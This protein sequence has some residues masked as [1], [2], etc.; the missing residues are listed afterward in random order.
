MT[1]IDF[2]RLVDDVPV[3]P[4]QKYPLLDALNEQQRVGNQK[5][6]DL[7]KKFALITRIRGGNQLYEILSK[8]LPLP[9]ESSIRRYLKEFGFVVEG[10]LQVSP[11]CI[12]HFIW[13]SHRNY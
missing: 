13:I 4:P 5:Y 12:F 8:N 6:G 10:E 7:L 3:Q 2:D 1:E 11:N 9:A